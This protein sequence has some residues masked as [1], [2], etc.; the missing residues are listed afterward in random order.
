MYDVIRAIL[1]F[2]C[3][4][5]FQIKVVNRP[6][7]NPDEGL[8]IC[9][10]H[11]SIM[12]IV[13]IAVTYP[14]RITFVGKK[15]LEKSPLA[16]FYRSM[17]TIFINRDKVEMETIRTIIHRLG[18]G[19]TLCI[20]PEGTRVKEVNPHNMKEGVGLFVQRTQCQVLP[21]HIQ[22]DYRFRGRI[23][24]EYRDF[25]DAHDV[26]AL[27]RKD[28]RPYLSQ[29]IFNAIYGTDYPISDFSQKD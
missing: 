1:R 12:D 5:A 27:P 14:G 6:H 16:F 13:V 8:I 25:L 24:V 18:K 22:A 11:Q 21:V 7:S 19:E 3:F 9:P 28:Q 17:G 26:K 2:L 23:T 10:N 20:F 29:K 15:E 4:F